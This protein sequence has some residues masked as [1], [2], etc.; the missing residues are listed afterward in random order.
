MSKLVIF[1]ANNLVMRSHFAM[2]Q[3]GLSSPNGRPSGALYGTIKAFFGFVRDLG[4]THVVWFFDEGRSDVRRA[5]RSDYKG[6]RKYS[7]VQT[8]DPLVDLPPQYEALREFFDLMGVRHHSQRGIEADDFIAKVVR[9]AEWP[10]RMDETVI[11]SGDHDMLQLV[12]DRPEV[13][14]FRP[15]EKAARP[16]VGLG[17]AKPVT[18]TL[19]RL[20]EVIAK[21]GLHPLKLAEAWALMGDTSDNITGIPGI[22]PKTAAKWILKHGSLAMALAKE[23]K[24]AGYERHCDVNRQMIQLDGSIGDPIPFGLDECEF[25]GFPISDGMRNFINR[26]GMKSLMEWL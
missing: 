19:Y 11:V 26:W 17:A 4:P 9:Q 13:N 5:L 16:S 3:S 15:G 10:R 22:G 1:D 7:S 23:P 25:Q 2:A 6:H 12:S 8:A 14:V 18:G 24:A 20:P 21:Y